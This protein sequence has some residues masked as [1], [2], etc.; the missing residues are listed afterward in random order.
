MTVPHSQT[1]TLC[2]VMKFWT[3]RMFTLFSTVANTNDKTI[4]SFDPNG[5]QLILRTNLAVKRIYPSLSSFNGKVIVIWLTESFIPSVTKASFSNYSAS[6]VA[7]S[8]P[9]GNNNRIQFGCTSKDCV[10]YRLMYSKNFYDIN[11]YQ[12]HMVHMQEKLSGSYIV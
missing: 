7:Q 9:I 10:L 5:R 1:F 4:L 11:S 6:L 8:R 2:M 3:N 12:Y